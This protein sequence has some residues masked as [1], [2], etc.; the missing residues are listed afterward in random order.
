MVVTSDRTLM[1]RCKHLKGQGLAA[2]REY[3]HD[4]IGYNYRMTNVAAAIGVAQLERIT[5]FIMRK[6]EIASLYISNLSDL[7]LEFQK[8]APETF[9][10]HWMFSI[11]LPEDADRDRFRRHLADA[12]IETRPLFY[13]VHTMPMYSQKFLRLPVSENIAWR[14]VNLPSWPGLSNEQVL[15]VC[16]A[17]REYLTT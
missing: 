6:R 12:G 10:S 1:N 7:D 8:E 3:W 2:H 17:I 5:S 14:G 4:A 15:I 13:P 11:L 16:S 9:H